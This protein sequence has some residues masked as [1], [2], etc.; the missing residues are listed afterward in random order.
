MS[1]RYSSPPRFLRSPGRLLTVMLLA[2][3]VVEVGVMR[4][5]PYLLPQSLSSQ[6]EAVIDACLLALVSAPVLWWLL[7]GPL[8]RIALAEMARSETIV[9]NASEG[10]ISIGAQGEIE[11]INR[12][13]LQL[14]AIELTDVIDH[15]IKKLI[16]NLDIG[17]EAP[18]Q[19]LYLNA[20]RSDG[21][22][23]PVSISFSKLPDGQRRKY[24]VIIHDLTETIKAEQ[25]RLQAVRE[26]EALRS[27]QM[28]NL[29]QLATGVAHEIRN[30]LTSIKMLIQAN[31]SQLEQEGTPSRDLELVEQEIRRMERSVNSL[32][33]YA[34]P[35]QSEF[36]VVSLQ[37][38]IERTK[39]L[40]E[41]R[42]QSQQVKLQIETA[43][44][45]VMVL[46]DSQQIGQLL[47]NLCLNGLDAMPQGGVMT[48][49]LSIK[50]K[51]AVLQVKDTGEGIQQKIL[52]H[53]FDPFLTTKKN[54][55]GLGLGICRRIAEQNHAKIE[56]FNLPQQ[57]ACFELKIPLEQT[58]QDAKKNTI[59][60][61]REV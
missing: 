12:S 26:K 22:H 28:T 53:L 6:A 17:E 18:N 39:R 57:G 46:V 11:S 60:Q 37:K 55:V 14:F 52:A 35:E 8:R 10:I 7:V 19:Q 38:I 31:R 13:G 2:I 56:G 49:A 47:L 27:Q 24:V 4:V 20:R 29:A 36:E 43:A 16:P 48:I 58:K 23:F 30:P 51:Q 15:S 25:E 42:C 32:L 45:P 5:L 54:G 50:N 21:V 3:F 59:T 33:D 34:R 61:E 44:E 41:S 40:I 1:Y 9:A